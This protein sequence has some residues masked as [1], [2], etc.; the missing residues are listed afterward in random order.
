MNPMALPSGL[1]IVRINK[2]LFVRN[3]TIWAAADFK[4]TL[5]SRSRSL[6]PRLAFIKKPDS[7][8]KPPVGLRQHE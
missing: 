1:Q 3:R 8:R 4:A 5:L 7:A 6:G 2:L